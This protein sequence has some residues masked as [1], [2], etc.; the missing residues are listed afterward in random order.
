[1]WE[2]ER[3]RRRSNPAAFS[4]VLA[5]SFPKGDYPCAT[6]T[7]TAARNAAVAAGGS[8]EDES[9]RQSAFAQDIFGNPF[10]LVTVYPDW[11]TSSAL[12]LAEGIYAE[13]AFDRLPI[14]ADALEDAGC[15]AAELLAHLRGDGPHVR[16][17]WALDLVL[18]KE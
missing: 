14:L 13:R 9:I 5:V 10:R 7:A 11:L 8:Q 6:D 12:S 17:C 3:A 1:M 18:G 15:D 4:A 16:G 2:G